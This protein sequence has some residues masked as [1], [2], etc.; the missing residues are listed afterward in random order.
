VPRGELALSAIRTKLEAQLRD[1]E[2]CRALSASTSFT[3]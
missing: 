2:R 3:G 1:L